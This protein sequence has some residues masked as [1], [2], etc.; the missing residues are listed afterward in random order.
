MLIYWLVQYVRN[1]WIAMIGTHWHLS[2]FTVVLNVNMLI[3]RPCAP[4]VTGVAEATRLV[5]LAVT[6]ESFIVIRANFSPWIHFFVAC[7]DADTL[8]RVFV[9]DLK[10]LYIQWPNSFVPNRKL[11]ANAIRTPTKFYSKTCTGSPQFRWEQ[12]PAIFYIEYRG[13]VKSFQRP[14]TSMQRAVTN[15]ND[16]ISKPV[17]M[18]ILGYKY[19]C[20]DSLTAF[21]K[22][23]KYRY[24]IFINCLTQCFPTWFVPCPTSLSNILM[25]PM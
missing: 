8:G 21:D 11:R 4:C 15:K 24:S 16:R 3:V 9:N 17:Q 6:P 25:P 5:H 10:L 18:M 14:T 12:S 19:C 2:A 7:F 20:K 22:T 1:V 13:M 23:A